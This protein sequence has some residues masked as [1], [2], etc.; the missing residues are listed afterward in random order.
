MGKGGEGKEEGK[1][2][3]GK[4][5]GKGDEVEGG[6]WPTQKFWSGAPYDAVHVYKVTHCSVLLFC[7]LLQ[8]AGVPYVIVPGQVWFPV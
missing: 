3:K 1:E 2:R 4:G 6:I 8:Y 5:V 7:K